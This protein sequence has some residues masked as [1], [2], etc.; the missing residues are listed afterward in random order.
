MATITGTN[1]SDVIDE[2]LDGGDPHGADEIF[3]LDGDDTIHMYNNTT[4]PPFYPSVTDVVH[5]G[6]G[7]DTLAFQ[8]TSGALIGLGGNA[9]DGYSGRHIWSNAYGGGNNS[10]ST[11][12]F[13][14]IER[15]DVEVS[16]SGTFSLLDTHDTVTVLNSGAT[17]ETLGGDDVVSVVG[18]TNTANLG[19]GNDRLVVNYGTSTI[20]V[21]MITPLTGSL[22]AGY[23]G[24]FYIAGGYARA[25]FTGSE[26]F[27][28]TTGSAGDTLVTGDGDDVISSQGGSDFVTAGQ[29]NDVL[30]GGGGIDALSIDLSDETEG[31]TINLLAA[32]A[33]QTGGTGSI[34]GF[35]SFAGTVT[36][37]AFGDTLI[38]GTFNYD[39]TFNTGAGDDLVQ[40]SDGTDTANLGD[41]NDRL[42]VDYGHSTVGIYMITPLTGTLAAGYSGAFYIAG[43]YARANFTGA[44]NFTVTSGS[45]GD[46]LVT[47][48]GNDVISSQGGNDFVT[49]GQGND[50]LDGG[51]GTDAL[52]I[53]L[54]DEAGGV[55]INLLAAGEQQT[56][57]TGSI[58]GFE[59]FAGTVTGSAFGDTLIEG[60]F[61]YN[62]TFNTGAGN[63]LVQ[64]SDGTD[65]ANLGDGSD[66]LVVDYGG[67]TVGVY[68]ITPLTGSE[69]AGYSGAFYIAGGYA[70]ANFTGAENFTVTSGS[71]GDTLVTGDGDDVIA[72]RA[73]SD[74]VT[75]GQ[76]NDV[77]DGGD[78]TDALSIDLSDEAGGV[79]I[80]L[81]LAGQQQTGGTGSITA[82]ESFA[83]T[84]TGSAFDD[85]LIEGAFNY[86][87]T[88][89]TGAGN[90]LV[91]VSD[92]TDTV[93]MG[94]GSDRLVVDYSSSTVRVYMIT[95]LSGS[96]AA[97]YSGAYYIAGG[98]ARA[99]F[100]GVEH[101]TVYGSS[102]G[103]TLVG[104]DG[105]DTFD[106]GAGA[107][108][109]TGGGGNDTYVVDIA[110]DV[111]TEG[112]NQGTD[113]VRTALAS[114]TLGANLENLTGTAATGQELTGNG[115]ANAIMAGAG[116]DMLSGGAGNDTLNGGAGTDTVTYADASSGV[117]V[118]LG[119]LAAQAV[120][121]GADTDRLSQIENLIGSGYGDTLLGSTLANVLEG[122]GGSDNLRGFA[123]NDVLIG[124]FGDDTLFGGGDN[125]TLTG[126]D[127][128]DLLR[129]DAGDDAMTGGAGDDTYYVDSLGDTVSELGGEGDDIVFARVSYTLGDNQ[130]RLTFYDGGGLTGTGNALANRI[131][132]NDAASFLY[133]LDGADTLFGNGGRDILDGGNGNDI[134]TG[135][136]AKD[137]MTGGAGR[138]T[139]RF[140]S[141]SDMLVTTGT[142]DII[143]DF[144]QS[145]LDR[146]QLNL[147]DANT[148]TAGVDDAFAFI[149]TA[150]F[151]GIAGQLR[152]QQTGGNTY[153]SGDVNGD[154]AADFFIRIDG[155]VTLV[156]GDFLL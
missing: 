113:L 134:L 104:G 34:T 122:R 59:S 7:S 81:L 141:L 55:T 11:L 119:V 85:T 124:G 111:V 3:G 17:V 102:A 98:Y 25:N 41:G 53:D 101:F 42:V 106:G 149:G 22:A 147:I 54:S 1:G 93:N 148:G 23:S 27:T 118:S 89:N 127:G 63:D 70:R 76:G 82:F 90:D 40:V 129:G 31:V 132:G 29:G 12:D 108:S 91:Q 107:D 150:A 120:G 62:T 128:N 80:N 47:G 66:R 133:G 79:T 154:A 130:E 138:D 137:E 99:N 60:A 50:V 20:G 117:S 49:S 136:A 74:F 45:A 16:G 58:T 48:D 92:G 52:S 8:M 94:D 69:A 86:D 65:T 155:T 116:D 146:I 13:D 152:Y 84:V 10:T 121:G 71:A 26:H 19:D 61:N 39:T 35:E 57:G 143:H 68:M 144:S 9:V 83:G 4:L 72:S 109:L 125:D 96:L 114:Y 156:A 123:G 30:D 36:G 145:D 64:V 88:F 95:P 131:S 18:G 103:D 126:G 51:A 77:L 37:S 140:T 97:G 139:F 87:T 43:G 14:G 33:Q 38:E 105:N 110:G 78:G 2:F 46:T 32:G 67:S 56:G 44:E 75:T 135:G 100:T 112:L 151:S 6:A 15:L 73:G 115:L 21:Y 5:G 24:A 142:A 153:V 28:V